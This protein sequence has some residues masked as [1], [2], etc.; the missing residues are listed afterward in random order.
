MIEHFEG[1]KPKI[2]EETFIHSC[3]TI[4]GQ[5]SIGKHSSVWPGAVIRADVSYATIGELCSVQDNACIHVD[6]G[7]PTIIGKGVT[8]GHGAMLHACS[9]D[10]WSLIGIGAIVL[11]GAKIGDHCIIAAGTIIPPGKTIPPKS[12]RGSSTPGDARKKLL[13]T[14]AKIFWRKQWQRTLGKWHSL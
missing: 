9:I 7:N 10:D 4:I 1:N 11:D 13:E 6:S 14:G 2:D 3:S 5:V 12:R 8:I